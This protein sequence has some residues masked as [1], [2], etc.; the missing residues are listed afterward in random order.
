MMVAQTSQY[1]PAEELANTLSH[2][3][4]AILSVLALVLLINQAST[5]DWIRLASV[6]LYGVSLVLLFLASTL[7]H[8]V[9][10]ASAKRLFKLLD[11]CAIYVLIAG[12][13][14]PLTLITLQGDLGLG[15]FAL[16][17][18]IALAG[19]LFKLKYGAKYK[20]LSVATYLGMGFISLAVISDL[21]QQLATNGLILLA[22]GGGVYTLGVF[23]YL[24]HKIP[25][26]H[27]IWH[28]FVLG[29]AACHFFMI[30][31]YV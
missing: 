4:G 10:S 7:Y 2:G 13:Y 21:S 27:A 29:G 1:S 26:N 9:K 11:H 24:N 31:F 6:T 16:V 15:M 28:L 25:F 22:L 30:W 19:I 18:G 14:T 8:G 12:T 23:F 20:I 3:L 5:D 17:W